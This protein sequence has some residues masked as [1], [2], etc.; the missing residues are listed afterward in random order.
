MYRLLAIDPGGTTGWATYTAERMFCY[1][2]KHEYYNEKWAS[3]QLTGRHHADLEL[4]IENQCVSEYTVI[5]ESFQHR[6][7]PLRPKVDNM[8]SEYI[9]TVS[10]ICERRGFNLVM[11]TSSM[12]KGFVKDTHIKSLGLWFPGYAKRHARDA[13]RHLL[14]YLCN[15]EYRV[16]IL[17]RGWR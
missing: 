2:G 5:C 15:K 11:Q 3:G 12:A 4:L 9:G 8:A 14:Y 6:N 10:T 7:D 16:D 13:Q 1:P 17:A